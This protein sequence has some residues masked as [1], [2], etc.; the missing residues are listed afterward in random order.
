MI[1][2]GRADWQPSSTGARG[3]AAAS[4]SSSNHPPLSAALNLRS[5]LGRAAE[6]VVEVAM[7]RRT[8]ASA[9]A[10]GPPQAPILSTPLV[11]SV[12]AGTPTNVRDRFAWRCGLLQVRGRQRVKGCGWGGGVGAGVSTGVILHS[13]FGQGRCACQR[14]SGRVQLWRGGSCPCRQCPGPVDPHRPWMVGE[15]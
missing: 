3:A 15:P 4:G 7:N 11:V 14:L 6:A 13:A 1:L 5:K 2:R 10:V 12:E 8:L 9:S